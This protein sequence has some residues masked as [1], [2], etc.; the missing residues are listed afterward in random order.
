MKNTEIIYGSTEQTPVIVPAFANLLPPLSD[1]QYA[2]LETDILHNGCYSPIIVSEDMTI[3]DGHHRHEICEKH[4]IP[5]RMVVFTFED[6]LEAQRWALETQKARRNL[7]VWELGQ[8]ALKLKSEIEARAEASHAANGGDKKS[9]DAKSALVNSP[10]P[11]SEGIDTRKELAQ[12]AGIGEQTMGRIMQIDQNAPVPVKDALDNGALSIN[13]G[14]NITRLLEKLPE[15]AREAAANRAIELAKQRKDYKAAFDISLNDMNAL[16]KED[17]AAADTI[18]SALNDGALSVNGGKEVARTLLEMPED[19][20]ETAVADAEGLARLEADY[21]K[22][23]QA[24]DD[25]ADIAKAYNAA[26]ACMTDISGSE[27]EVRI[28]IEWA[29]IR[30]DEIVGLIEEAKNAASLFSQIAGV[31]KKIH[32]QEVVPYEEAVHQ[33]STE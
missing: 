30:K 5:Y 24:V 23:S 8:I 33:S 21:R 6:D 9:A 18:R 32:E 17:E 20:R 22:K 19:V 4:N 15:E 31:L 26:F 28:W 11:I 12:A 2:A 3:V 14:Y 10:K 13:A 25:N 27:R 29:G 16:T 7:S 1:E